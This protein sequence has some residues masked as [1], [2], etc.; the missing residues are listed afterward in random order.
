MKV[1]HRMTGDDLDGY[2]YENAD[3]RS[4]TSVSAGRFGGLKAAAGNDFAQHDGMRGPGRSGYVGWP[5]MHGGM[6]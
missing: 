1:V 4:T 2:R 5:M 6:C 3:S